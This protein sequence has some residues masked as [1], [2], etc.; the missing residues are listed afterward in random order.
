MP[1]PRLIPCLDVAEG[2]VVKGVRFAS[3]RRVGDPVGLA[4][5]YSDEGADEIVLLD[6]RA[7]VAGHRPLL[8]LVER[9]AAEVAIPITVGGGLRS[10]ADAFDL[11]SAGA[12]KICLNTAAVEEPSLVTRLAERYGCQAVVVAIDAL[13]GEVT[14]RAGTAPAGIGAVEWARR[15]ERLGA[16][17]ILLT[18]MDADGTLGGYDVELTGA[19]AGAVRLPVIASGGAGCAAHVAEVLEIAQ[20]ALVASIVHE[21]PDGLRAL[22]REVAARGIRLREAEVQVA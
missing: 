15:V 6:V 7:T 4:R 20:A 21:R 12:D 8:D 18:S 1:Y 22:R 10:V 13:G 14:T 19:V 5:R 16:G 2:A 3:L 11:F 17:E 9:V